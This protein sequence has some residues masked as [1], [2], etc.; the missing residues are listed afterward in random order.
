M[1]NSKLPADSEPDRRT[2]IE[3]HY[4]LESYGRGF[5]EPS[6]SNELSSA[7]AATASAAAEQ[8]GD[9]G[10]LR[11][12]SVPAPCFSFEVKPGPGGSWNLHLFENGEP[13]GGGQFP[14]EDYCEALEEGKRWI[15]SRRGPV[16]EGGC[17]CGGVD[18]PGTG[19]AHL[20][21]CPAA[22]PP[23][24]RADE[25]D[26]LSEEERGVLRASRRDSAYLR[27]LRPTFWS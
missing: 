20:L 16:A 13:A 27:R 26:L 9:G 21:G 15:E 19:V 7:H 2:V 10:G 22:F 11:P 12:L 5:P 6:P 18:I 24:G 25:Q 1:E 14:E 3:E 8:S 4:G 17:T 23:G